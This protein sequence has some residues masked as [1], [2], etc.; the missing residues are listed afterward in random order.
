[1]RLLATRLYLLTTTTRIV[2]FGQS[3]E[4]KGY[5]GDCVKGLPEK[6]REPQMDKRRR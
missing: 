4:S 3:A 6:Q 5:F 1:M 2:G